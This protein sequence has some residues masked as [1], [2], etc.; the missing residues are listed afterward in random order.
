MSIKFKPY[1]NA[2]TSSSDEISFEKLM[3]GEFFCCGL[4]RWFSLVGVAD[5]FERLDTF[6]KKKIKSKVLQANNLTIVR[7]VFR[8]LRYHQRI[9]FFFL[10]GHK[11]PP[12]GE[13]AVGLRVSA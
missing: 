1:C 13:N 10:C 12:S 4:G 7:D 5:M 8:L 2:V 6:D 9:I 3:T 11:G